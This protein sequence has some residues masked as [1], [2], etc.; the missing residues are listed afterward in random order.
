MIATRAP[1][2]EVLAVTSDSSIAELIERAFEPEL[3]PDLTVVATA[4]A[5]L[6]LLD[7]ELPDVLIIDT[8]TRGV[9]ALELCVAVRNRFD[10]T[11]LALV[12]LTGPASD[13]VAG[14]DAGA[15]DHLT[16][17]FNARELG[18]R[19]RALLRRSGPDRSAS[20][21]IYRGK[22]LVA[23]FDALMVVVDGRTVAL[24]QR[25]LT[26]LHHLVINANRVVSRTRLLEQV[27]D[28]RGS[29]ETRTVD[30]YVG[31]LRRKLGTA[32][33]QIETVFGLGYRFVE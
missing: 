31:R 23:D 14:L 27:W 12:M 1:R 9:D 21:S 20:S 17:P 33:D 15:D 32:G 2:I 25:E 5:A 22:H 19:V 26:L 29:G 10:T 30:V 24:T 7:T 6:E 13:P 16:K 18:A 8:E 3:P 11:Q 4:K 28:Y